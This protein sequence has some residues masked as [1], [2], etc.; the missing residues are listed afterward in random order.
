MIEFGRTK[1]GAI[2]FT[3]SNSISGMEQTNFLF[4]QAS[5]GTNLIL[6]QDLVGHFLEII[7][8]RK[9]T[10]VNVIDDDGEHNYFLRQVTDISLAD[11]VEVA[12]S[13]HATYVPHTTEKYLV[14]QFSKVR[15]PIVESLTN[16]LMMHGRNNG[17]KLMAIR[18]MK[19]A[20]EIIH[21]LTDHN[22]I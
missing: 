21:L 18:I 17:K 19:H 16:S 5:K 10:D 3:D 12:A 15:C 9:S 6:A 13:K 1:S 11:Y 2:I 14:K 22:P 20:M 7:S 8:G 4:Q